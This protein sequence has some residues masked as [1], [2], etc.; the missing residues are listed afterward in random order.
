MTPS[1]GQM[2]AVTGRSGYDDI[3]QITAV[4]TNI[5]ARIN[6]TN[7]GTGVAR[8]NATN[9]E[10][11]LQTGGTTALKIDT[12]QRV[13]IGTTSESN[14][15][16][17]LTVYRSQVDNNSTVNEQFKN[18]PLKVVKTI[19]AVNLRGGIIDGWDGNI[20]GVGISMLYDGTRY[21]MGFGVNN[22]TNNRPTERMSIG[23]DGDVTINDGNLIIGTSGHGIDFSAGS[24][25]AGMTSELLDDYEEGTWTGGFND[26]NGS[27]TNNT[28]RYTKIGDLVT[29]SIM[30]SGSGH[31]TGSG[32]LILT[33]LP[34]A[35]QGTPASYRAVG[36]VHAHTGLVTGGKQVIGLMNN[37]ENKVRIRTV[38]NNSTTTDL[39]RNG[40]N[41]GG[42]EVVVTITYQTAS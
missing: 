32:S 2:M 9:N 22:D 30:V 10:L 19:S 38:E 31:H 35:S 8:I 33:S 26:Y 41:S 18:T 29:V 42:W 39:N 7:T 13:I 37:N 24:N 16:T 11:Q 28:G 27:Y 21:H 4:G 17:V 1:N 5:G 34:Y 40:L 12:S 23:G 20:H 3:V 14:A 36:S 25:A 15:G 6:L